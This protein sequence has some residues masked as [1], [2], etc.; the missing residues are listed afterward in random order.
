M[1]LECREGGGLKTEPSPGSL[2]LVQPLL[3]LVQGDPGKGVV[4]PIL[5]TQEKEWSGQDQRPRR[6]SDQA[7]KKKDYFKV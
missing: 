2:I 1:G 5:E 3:L 7:I 4:R 6:R